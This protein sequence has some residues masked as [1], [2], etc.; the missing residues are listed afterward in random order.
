MSIMRTSFPPNIE[1]APA[2][3]VLICFDDIFLV[4]FERSMTLCAF[5]N[6]GLAFCTQRG[7]LLLLLRCRCLAIELL[8]PE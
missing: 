6:K 7:L 8:A 1:I 4:A 3:V 2:S 5:D